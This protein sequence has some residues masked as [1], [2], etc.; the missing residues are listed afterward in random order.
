MNVYFTA[1]IKGKQKYLSHYETIV[2]CVKKHHHSII[3]D[4][5]LETSEEQISLE[6]IEERKSFHKKL[7]DW[8]VS[9]DCVIAEISF[10]ST[11]VGFEIS[12]ALE[13]GK[14]VLVLYSDADRKPPSLLPEMNIERLI[15]EQYTTF[16]KIDHIV[17]DFL[18]YVSG[19]HDTRFTFFLP[20]K[21]SLKLSTAAKKAHVAKSVYIRNLLEKELQ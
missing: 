17:N 14:P 12:K 8:I 11:S 15:V 10:P 19:Q 20:Y 2:D 7:D 16:D 18:L 9:A 4:H 5:I 6:T 3:S 13:K 21:L 1:S